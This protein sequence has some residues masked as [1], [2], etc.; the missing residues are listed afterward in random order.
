MTRPTIA[1]ARLALS[2][3]CLALALVPAAAGAAVHFQHE[4]FP[5]FEH[6][7]AA[8]QIQAATFNKKAHTLHLTLNDGRHVLVSYPSHE[9][10][11]LAAR[12]EGKGV[13]VTVEKKKKAK[14]AVHHKLRYIAGGILIV[15]I[16]VVAA[17]LL[18]DRRRRL[19]AEGGVGASSTPSPS[20]GDSG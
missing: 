12:L 15:V 20:S 2:T 14:A 8:G 1:F 19:N 13:A 5:E 16:L 3:A 6:Q 7:L 18:V 17:V 9:E 10:P 4:G 11:Q